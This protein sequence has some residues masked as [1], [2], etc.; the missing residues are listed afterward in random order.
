MKRKLVRSMLAAFWWCIAHPWYVE[1]LV[2]L[3]FLA[4]YRL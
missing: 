4:W 1:Q 3:A 2:Y